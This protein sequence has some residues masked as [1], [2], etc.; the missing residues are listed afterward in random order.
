[1]VSAEGTIEGIMGDVWVRQRWLGVDGG[2]GGG[3]QR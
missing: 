2:C 1:M 3:R